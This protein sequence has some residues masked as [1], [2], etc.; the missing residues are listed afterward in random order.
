MYPAK[1]LEVK[2]HIPHTQLTL[3]QHAT[4]LH[5]RTK[6]ITHAEQIIKTI[7]SSCGPYYNQHYIFNLNFKAEHKFILTAEFLIKKSVSALPTLALKVCIL[8]GLPLLANAAQKLFNTSSITEGV[9]ET[10]RNYI[11]SAQTLLT[12]ADF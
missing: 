11:S 10:N 2:S 4:V 1:A 9:V 5:T 12:C 6:H 3:A 8:R 7:S